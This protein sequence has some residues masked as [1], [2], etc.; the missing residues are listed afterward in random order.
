M[1]RLSNSFKIILE[2]SKWS[3]RFIKTNFRKITDLFKS[4]GSQFYLVINLTK[5]VLEDRIST[6]YKKVLDLIEKEKLAMA[7]ILGRKIVENRLN[8]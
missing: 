6:D 3:S 7:Y 2:C 8:L 4:C 1:E 5:E